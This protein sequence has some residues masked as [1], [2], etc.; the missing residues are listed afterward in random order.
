VELAH[1]HQIH[2]EAEW[3]EATL[4]FATLGLSVKVQWLRGLGLLLACLGR[5]FQAAVP[6][7]AELA[8]P[9]CG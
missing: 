3:A 8:V 6:A 7:A 2:T 1:G 9:Q 5:R 4:L